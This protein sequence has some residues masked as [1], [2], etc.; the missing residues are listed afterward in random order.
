[1]QCGRIGFTL[2]KPMN[3]LIS[4]KNRVFIS[5]VGPSGT[6]KLQFIY[7]WLKIGTLQPNFD[8]I[9]FFYQHSQPL[10]D[11]MQKEIENLEFVQGVNFEFFDS[12]KNN[13]TK[14]LLIFDDSCEEIC[15]SKAFVDIA[16]AGRHRGLSTIYIKH[17]LFHQ[18]KLGRDVELQ[19]THIV[20]FKSPLDVMQLATPSTQLGLGSELIEWYRDATSVP[21]GH[22][23]IDLSPRTDDR[24]RYCTNSGSVPSKLYIPESLEHLRALDDEHTKSLYSP[25]VPIAFPKMQQPLSSVLPKRIYPVSMRMHSKSTQR[26]LASHEKTSR[27]KVSIRSLATIAKKNNL[28]AKKKRSV[29][30]KRIAT[31]SSHY[32]SCH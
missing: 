29:V 7:I 13:G 26:K 17:N 25:S 31:N 8:K 27:G 14:Y 3:K 18:S 15:N 6:R 21:F 4:T 11:V 10:Y 1:M 9:Y 16:I 24:L 12:L 20:L 5:L 23:L 2:T 32:A 28:E 30:T 19:N 22:L